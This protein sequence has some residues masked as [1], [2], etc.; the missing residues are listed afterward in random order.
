MDATRKR[1]RAKLKPAAR[2][3][4]A[5]RKRQLMDRAKHLFVT[6]G[7]QQTTTEKIAREAGVTEPVLYR[8]FDNK[9]ALF[10]EVLD[11]IRLATIG[12]WQSETAAI[13]DPLQRLHAIVDL[14]LGSTRAHALDFH[15][16]HRS[17]VETDDDDIAECLRRFYLDSETMLTQ[18]IQE[19]QAAGAF[20]KDLD[21][22]VGAWELIRTAL[23]YTLTLP[24]GIPIYEEKDYVP[25]AIECMMKC[26][27]V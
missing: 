20:R 23:G 5:D 2:M 17:L 19:G 16:M 15:I 24:L 21:P 10:L 12:R 8:H 9:K 3:R 22:R 7:Y 18:V 26:L 6:L 27:I 1:R 4:K 11:D 14:Y 25:R 13:A